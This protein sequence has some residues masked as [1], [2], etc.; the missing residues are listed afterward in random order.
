MMVISK[1]VI[2]VNALIKRDGMAK[3]E[4]A[5]AAAGLLLFK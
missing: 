3:K 1:L 4:C 5:E 2:I